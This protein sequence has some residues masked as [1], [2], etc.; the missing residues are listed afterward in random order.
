MG[1]TVQWVWQ[2]NGCGSA[3]GVAV[4]WVWWHTGWEEPYNGGAKFHII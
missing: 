3:V 1:V 4:Q 2:C